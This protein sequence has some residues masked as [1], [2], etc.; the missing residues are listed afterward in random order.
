MNIFVS[1]TTRDKYIDDNLLTAASEVIADYGSPYIDLLHN[2]SEDKQSHVELK[3][4]QSDLL[5]LLSSDSI[6]NSKWVQ[7]E[8][9]EAKKKGIP[10]I[11]VQTS[12]DFVETLTILK[13]RLFSELNKLTRRS[14][15]D[16]ATCAV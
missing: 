15:N 8:L 16:A 13:H 2:D 1:Y 11:D 14:S 6:K 4:S 5:L 3:L 7:W 10:V 9:K 12:S